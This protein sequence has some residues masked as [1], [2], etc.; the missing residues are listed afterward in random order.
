MLPLR[1]THWPHAAIWPDAFPFLG[2]PSWD[3]TVYRYGDRVAVLLCVEVE[4]GR[5]SLVI[6]KWSPTQATYYV[7]W[8]CPLVYGIAWERA[9][10]VL[11]EILEIERD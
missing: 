2:K 3:A 7:A 10:T 1:I 4:P 8:E 9:A 5:S 11:A 6:G